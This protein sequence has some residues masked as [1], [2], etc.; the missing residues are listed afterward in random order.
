MVAAGSDAAHYRAV[1]RGVVLKLHLQSYRAGV[2]SWLIPNGTIAL[3]LGKLKNMSES[4]YLA[5]TRRGNPIHMRGVSYL[6]VSKHMG[7]ETS[8]QQRE[9]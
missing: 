1:L 8:S 3:R 5:E 2:C 4:V 6:R 9:P 7:Y